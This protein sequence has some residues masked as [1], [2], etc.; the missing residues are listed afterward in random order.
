M[1][2]LRLLAVIDRLHRATLRKRAVSLNGCWVQK[3]AYCFDVFERFHPLQ[4]HY[5]NMRCRISF[6]HICDVTNRVGH[7]TVCDGDLF[8][9]GGEVCLQGLHVLGQG[10]HFRWRRAVGARHATSAATISAALTTVA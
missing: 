6:R 2:Q 4:G 9:G 10:V 1:L 3:H 7:G 5:P 8:D